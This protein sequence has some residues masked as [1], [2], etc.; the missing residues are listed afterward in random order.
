MGS[1]NSSEN[2]PIT[3]WNVTSQEANIM[4]SQQEITRALTITKSNIKNENLPNSYC[5]NQCICTSKVK[6]Q[7]KI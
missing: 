2:I 3:T 6:G 1:S 7:D 5:I 4:T